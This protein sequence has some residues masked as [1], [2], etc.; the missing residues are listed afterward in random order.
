MPIRGD[1][2]DQA[3]SVFAKSKPWCHMCLKR[4]RPLCF[5]PVYMTKKEVDEVSGKP[6]MILDYNKMKGAVDHVDQLC[7]N[8]S[9]QR[10]T[11]RWPLA[12]FYNCLNLAAINAQIVFVAKFPGWEAGSPHRRRIFL[13]NLGLQLLSP[14]LQERVQVPRLPRA[15]QSALK[16]C[17]FVK[18]NPTE[19]EETGA[20]K[21]RRCHICPSSLDR[22]TVDRCCE[23]G[24]PCCNDH[25]RVTVIC[26][27]CSH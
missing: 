8:Y 19:E 10:R 24:Q 13:E 2:S 20:R 6:V 5:Y 3:C 12:Y 17:G 11:T 21:R 4:T 7:H 9:V 26:N 23:C 27:Y 1:L 25:K 14:W 15:S 22:K 18:Q 16:R